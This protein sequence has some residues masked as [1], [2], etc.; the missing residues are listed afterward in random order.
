MTQPKWFGYTSAIRLRPNLNTEDVNR[1]PNRW[2]SAMMTAISSGLS[3]SERR[4]IQNAFRFALSCFTPVNF[5]SSSGDQLLDGLHFA[6]FGRPSIVVVQRR[7]ARHITSKYVRNIWTRA[8]KIPI[9]RGFHF[10]AESRVR[11]LAIKILFNGI[12]VWLISGIWSPRV[13]PSQAAGRAAPGCHC[14]AKCSVDPGIGSDLQLGPARRGPSAFCRE[15]SSPI[16]WCSFFCTS[17]RHGWFGRAW[18]RPVWMSIQDFFLFKG[19]LRVSDK[20]IVVSN[21]RFIRKK[22][23]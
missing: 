15:F 18:R 2:S 5:H 23:L 3:S 4:N 20:L 19:D 17:C 13:E 11:Y 21:L 22:K 16:G 12:Q 9:F 14:T 8:W 7:H 1:P 6:A 10:E